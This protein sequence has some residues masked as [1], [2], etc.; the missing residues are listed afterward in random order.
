M[1]C[2]VYDRA[3]SRITHCGQFTS[4]YKFKPI[5]YFP[6]ISQNYCSAVLPQIINN[7]KAFAITFYFFFLHT[8]TLMS[9]RRRSVSNGR[10]LKRSTVGDP[11]HTEETAMLRA[12]LLG[13]L[14]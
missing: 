7:F 10:A 8:I 1:V 11:V 2:V 3:N 4:V 13:Y 5:M 6:V 9:C 14:M 12:H